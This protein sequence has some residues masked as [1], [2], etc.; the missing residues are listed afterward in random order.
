[1]SDTKSIRDT[2]FFDYINGVVVRDATNGL[3][4]ISGN[5]ASPQDPYRM[6][7]FFRDMS[8]WLSQNMDIV[9]VHG[10]WDNNTQSY[11]FTVRQVKPRD[12][13]NE[14]PDFVDKYRIK[15]A[16]YNGFTISFHESSNRWQ[17]FHN[18]V[19]EHFAS[20]GQA[21]VSFVGGE[22]FLHYSNPVKNNYYGSTFDTVTAQICNQATNNI[23]VF[24]NMEIHSNDKWYATGSPYGDDIFILPNAQFPQGMRSRLDAAHFRGKEGKWNASMLRDINTPG[25]TNQTLSLV[26]GRRLRGDAMKVTLRNRNND[27]VFLRQLIIH[28]T[29][30][31]I[32]G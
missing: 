5:L 29:P 26:G 22:A 11:F 30:S 2:Y 9:E 12:E 25:F 13:F 32:S 8:E 10:A 4:A 18:F 15:E 17:T 31:E 20:I 23:K 21:F 7:S 14:V 27:A 6:T 3:V 24:D 16:W 19:P 28:F 1:M